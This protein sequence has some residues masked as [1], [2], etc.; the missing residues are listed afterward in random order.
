MCVPAP[1]LFQSTHMP[2]GTAVNSFDC[3]S[4]PTSSLQHVVVHCFSTQLHRMP[5][6]LTSCCHCLI[7]SATAVVVVLFFPSAGA[8]NQVRWVWR[9][10]TSESTGRLGSQVQPGRRRHRAE[11][12]RRL[13]P[14][15]PLAS[16]AAAPAGRAGW[17]RA[18]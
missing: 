6:W 1:T 2:T 10:R 17:S 11:R 12:I 5:T 3:N 7:C 18:F 13:L 15:L 9:H 14:S 16:I 4:R 8:P